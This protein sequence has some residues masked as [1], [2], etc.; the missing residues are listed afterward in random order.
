[1][2]M[3]D[4]KALIQYR[5]SRAKETLGEVRDLEEH[6]HWNAAI[7]RLY[8]ACFYAVSALILTRDFQ[9]KSHAGVRHLFGLH[10]VKEGVISR[11]SGKFYSDLFDLRQLG[12][13]DDFTEFNKETL[14][15]LLP[16]A[17][18]FIENIENFLKKMA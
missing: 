15:D 11:E 9:A 8:Y 1:M 12:D 4:K 14:K 7:S 3:P 2:T 5:L 17:E 16:D 10:F 18:Q 6:G 13:Y